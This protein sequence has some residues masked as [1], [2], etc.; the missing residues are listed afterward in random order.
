[1]HLPEPLEIFIQYQLRRAILPR[2]RILLRFTPLR[3]HNTAGSRAVLRLLNEEVVAPHLL[4]NGL[5]LLLA[6]PSNLTADGDKVEVALW[7][8]SSPLEN[9]C[10][11]QVFVA[12]ISC[13]YEHSIRCNILIKEQQRP[14]T[15]EKHAALRSLYIR[16]KCRCLF[17]VRRYHLFPHK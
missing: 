2:I 15:L 8:I 11:S 4:H 12:E 17:R 3:R 1:M 9:F 14:R 16:Q 13:F 6:P 7:W 10:W 5:L